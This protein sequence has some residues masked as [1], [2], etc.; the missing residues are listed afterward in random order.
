MIF[1]LALIGGLSFWLPDLAAHVVAGRRFDSPHVRVITF[2]MP[3]TFV[4]AYLIVRR[5]A[6]KRDFRWV[7]GAMLL[8]VWLSGGLFMTL[9][10]TVSQGG[11][12]GPDG[13]RGGLLMIALSVVPIVTYMMAA[14][15]GSLGALLAVTLGA[16]LVVGA[17]KMSGTLVHRRAR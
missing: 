8:G 1:W 12:A 14:Y 11:F 17:R 10:A 16:L 2:L 15:D 4:I 5:F 9:A 3:I 13:V 6:A 7:G